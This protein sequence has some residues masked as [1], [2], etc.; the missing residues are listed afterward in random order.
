MLLATHDAEEVWDLCDR[1]G[2]LER[3]HL[4]AVDTTAAL[5]HRAGNDRYRLWIRSADAPGV[6]ARAA[7][8]GSPLSPRGPTIEAGWEEFECGIEGNA[9]GA[10]RL[11]AALGAEGQVLA[12]FE[13]VAPSLADL[14]ERV[15]R[16][17]GRGAPHA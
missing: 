10:A 11:L 6:M 16:P 13:R 7:G 17:A 15:L 4:L 3:G 12:R 9:E 5:R 2:V 1:V 14:I 8:L